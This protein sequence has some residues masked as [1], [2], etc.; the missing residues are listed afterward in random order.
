MRET[1]REFLAAAAGA[2]L[3]LAG[4]GG[5]SRSDGAQVT[6]DFWNGFTGGDGPQMLALVQAVEKEHPEIRVRMVTARWEDFYT[7]LPAA[8]A[9]GEGPDVALMHVDQIPTNAAHR[10]IMPLDDLVRDLDLQEDDFAAPVW[11]AGAV[12]GRRYGVPLDMHPI[13]LYANQQVLS[14][15]G[16]DPESLPTTRDEYESALEELKGKGVQGHWVTPFFFTGGHQFMSLLWQFGG[17][18][19]DPEATRATWNSD[20]GVEALEWMRSLIA[21]GYSPRNVG[22]DADSIA[23]KN[24]QNAFIWNGAWAIGD[25]GST[26]GLE[27]TLAPLPKI[28]SVAAAWSNSH[29]FTVMRQPTPDPQRLEAV[30]VLIDGV[31]RSPAW[32]EA[33]QIPA[34]RS[35]RESEAFR[36]LEAQSALARQ[37]PD[38]RFAAAAPGLSDV[39]ESTLDIAVAQAINGSRPVREAL[40]DSA[41]RA[42]EL[43]AL[44]REKYGT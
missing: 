10:T 13:G 33:G 32:A 18:L 42:N 19:T 37:V 36:K 8:V 39:R 16:L 21:K 44:N 20:A 27:W 35:A 14:E 2:A 38:L 26:E 12:D 23:F 31:T 6:L 28:G 4:C 9:S 41:R 29:N 11:R 7:K 24:G 30:K 34:R 15:A 22:Q 5:S 3:V 43:L 40:D 17:D 25:Y 1:R